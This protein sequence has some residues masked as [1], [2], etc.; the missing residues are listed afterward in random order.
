MAGAYSDDC[1][2]RD[3]AGRLSKSRWIE[4]DDLANLRCQLLNYGL[5]GTGHRKRAFFSA[6]KLI[7][8]HQCQIRAP[9]RV[10]RTRLRS[11]GLVFS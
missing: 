1:P 9:E 7:A 10:R 6:T 11:N 4:S 2:T 3:N 8:G 5:T